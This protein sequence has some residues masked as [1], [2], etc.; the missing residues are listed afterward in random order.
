MGRNDNMNE[1]EHSLIELLILSRAKYIKSYTVY[2]W[3]SGFTH[4]ISYI[5]NIP[6]K[7]ERNIKI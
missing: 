7:S 5:Y 1:I 6:L 2:S 3:I 4:M